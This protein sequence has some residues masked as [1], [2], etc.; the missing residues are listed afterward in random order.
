MERVFQ[1]IAQHDRCDDWLVFVKRASYATAQTK[2]V[3]TEAHHEGE[4]LGRRMEW[5][6][7]VVEWVD[8]ERIVWRA[9]SGQAKRM[10][11]M[12]YNWVKPEEGKARYSLEVRYEMPY[13]FIGRALDALW[14]RRRLRE[15]LQ[16]SVEQLKAVLE[17]G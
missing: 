13:S 11:M 12:A 5:D 17:G 7:E 16:K 2:G 10:K 14:V 6:G 8:N 4:M 3:G 15:D 1:R 9:T